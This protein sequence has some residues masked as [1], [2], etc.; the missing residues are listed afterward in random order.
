M[1]LKPD[2]YMK[3]SKFYYISSMLNP[4]S[5]KEKTR[6]ERRKQTHNVFKKIKSIEINELNE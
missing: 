2:L 3:F 6:T 5:K 4:I 1:T